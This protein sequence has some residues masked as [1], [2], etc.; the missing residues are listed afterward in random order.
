MTRTVFLALAAVMLACSGNG[1]GGKI[2][3]PDGVP[4]DKTSGGDVSGDACTPMCEGKECGDD[5]C[6]GECGACAPLTEQCSAEGQC[7]P[8]A[9][10][11]TKDCPGDLICAD[12]LGQCVACVGDEDCPE[13]TKCAAD[14]ACHEEHV[15]NSDKQCK[16]FDLVCDKEAGQCV[17]CLKAE[18]CAQGEYCK[19]GY[20]IETACPAGE[21]KCDGADVLACSADGSGW[22]V[23]I[24]CPEQQYCEDGECKA[25]LCTPSEKFCEGDVLNECAGDGKS[26]VSEDDC[27]AKEEHCFD[28]AC[29]DTVCVPSAKFCADPATAATCLADGMDFSTLPCDAGQYCD[30]SK[31]ECAAQV[32]LPGKTECA[33]TVAKTCNAVG[34]GYASQVDC[35]L[36]GK[37][38]VNG[39]CLDLACP[40]S[41][42]FCVDGDTLGHCSAD[43]LSFTSEDCAAKHSCKD[44]QCQP[45]QCTPNSPMCSGEVATVCD[46]LGLG[47]TPGGTD[48]SKSGKFCSD[49]QCTAC[50]PKCDGKQCGDDGCGGSCGSCNDGL[51]CTTDSCSVGQCEFAI[52]QFQCVI[53]GSCVPSGTEDPESVCRKCNPAKSQTDWSNLDDQTP[54]GGGGLA[55]HGGVC[56]IF[57]CAGKEC[58]DDGCGGGCGTCLPGIS[59]NAGLCTG[60]SDGNA[61]DWDGCTGGALSEFQVNSLPTGNQERASV[62]ASPQGGYMVVWQSNMMGTYDVFGRVYADDGTPTGAEFIPHDSL[63]KAQSYPRVAAL[64]DGRFVVVWESYPTASVG[65][66]IW[67]QLVNPDGTEAGTEFKV[68]EADGKWSSEGLDVAGFDKGGFVVVWTRNSTWPDI[69][70]STTIRIRRFAADGSKVGAESSITGASPDLPVVATFQDGGYVVAWKVGSSQLFLYWQQFN[71]SGFPLGAQTKLADQASL[72]GAASMPGGKFVLTWPY[73]DASLHPKTVFAQLFAK[74]SGPAGDAFQVSPSNDITGCGFVRPAMRADGSFVVAWSSAKTGSVMGD[75]WVQMVDAA[76]AKV[77]GLLQA[78]VFADSYQSNPDVALFADG[79]AI[80]V[81]VSPNQDGNGFGIFAQRFDKNGNKLYH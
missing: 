59:C 57:N 47:S 8:F 56:C 48:C 34:S 7:E 55:C 54:C 30:D 3:P 64:S 50:Q 14:H 27:A 16:E 37:V 21:S 69:D 22:E 5:G 28:G 36:Q 17:Q 43:G 60:C 74:D 31:G 25:Y 39:Q 78:N 46:A 53:K 42:D 10:E 71:S 77:G 73:L 76:G 20:C 72:A 11:S 26:V 15:C 52:D 58:G 61:V 13:G 19:D 6:G 66:S 33:G 29:I 79:T 62:A 80:V 49:G 35:K 63:E 70:Q 44:G 32:C 68:N 67:A 1:T 18:H 51:L 38:C 81:W 4:S 75:V 12:D 40:P 24:T 41:T 2:A 65:S 9:C 45:W 23:S